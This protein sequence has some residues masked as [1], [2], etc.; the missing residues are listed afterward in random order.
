MGSTIGVMST[1]LAPA[2]LNRG[3]GVYRNDEKQRIAS[4]TRVDRFPS[5]HAACLA[6]CL[7]RSVRY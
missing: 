7:G 2:G 5:C 6:R 1:K 3:A 4:L